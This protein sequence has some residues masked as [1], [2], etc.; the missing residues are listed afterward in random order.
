VLFQAG[1]DYE[2]PFK[3]RLTASYVGSRTRRIAISRNLNA[4]PLAERLKGVASA[5]YLSQAV[6]NPFAG[7]PEL[8]GTSLGSA[9]MSRNQSLMPFP[10]F[11]S[12]TET[13]YSAGKSWYNGLEMRVNKRFS[14]GLNL[15]LAY[16]F[17][18]AME[19]TSYLEPQYTFLDRELSS[20]DRTHNLSISA[21]YE[22]PVGKGKRYLNRMGPLLDRIAGHWQVNSFFVYLNGAPL[23]MPNAIPARD[24]RLRGTDQSLLRYF[25]TC[26]LLVNGTR[27]NCIGDEPVT[28]IQLA[29]N[30]LRTFS[31][32]SPN[33]RASFLPR[34]NLSV[35][36]I[37]PIRERIRLEFRASAFNAFNGKIYGSPNTTLTAATFGQVTLG[38]QANGP[39]AGEL[40]LRLH[41]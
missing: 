21:S 26:T 35:F 40:A 13:A 9:T 41:W 38:S 28:C 3:T 30:Q 7:A 22:L 39:R 31:L 19:A 20:W 36:K 6:P 8:L 37:I 16:T 1:F 34:T 25:D 11:T 18:K 24:P 4:I 27:S 2:L 15:V 5:S 29:T 23:A 17:A 33:M 14:Q 12:I 10:Q 32:Y